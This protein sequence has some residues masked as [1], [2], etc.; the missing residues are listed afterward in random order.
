MKKWLIVLSLI[1]LSGCGFHLQNETQIPAQ[2][3]TMIFTS[4]DPFGEL[5]REIKNL[6][7]DN[8]VKLTVQNDKNPYPVLQVLTSNLNKNTISVYQ[9]GKAAEYQLIL[10]V[11]AQITLAG[12]DIYPLTVKVFRTFFDN[13]STALA[14]STEQSLI[15]KEMH[16]QAAKQLIAKLKTIDVVDQKSITK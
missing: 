2:F 4:Y 7:M 1:T 6:L 11:N 8:K 13:P 15:E 10:T 12:K 9:D 3:Q 5:S 14:K 16:N